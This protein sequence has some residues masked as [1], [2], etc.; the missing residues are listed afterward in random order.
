MISDLIIERCEN[1]QDRIE[2]GIEY[3]IT[4]PDAHG[5]IYPNEKPF[6]CEEAG[7][8]M[9]KKSLRYNAKTFYLQVMEYGGV[10]ADKITR[11]M[12]AGTEYDVKYALIEYINANCF[13]SPSLIEYVKQHEW[14]QNE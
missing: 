14:L 3:V 2:R 1:E 10:F 6:F 8:Q 13:G 7:Q 9:I 11:A 5:R 4:Y 12:D